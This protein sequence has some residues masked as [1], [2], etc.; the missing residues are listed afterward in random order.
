M[1][2]NI[3]YSHFYAQT[4]VLSWP[5]PMIFFLGIFWSQLVLFTSSLM[6][7][8]GKIFW[9]ILLRCA[10]V[11]STHSGDCFW[12]TIFYSVRRTSFQTWNRKPGGQLTLF[13]SLCMHFY[14]W[15]I[16]V[17]EYIVFVFPFVRSYV[18]SC[19]ISVT[20]KFLVKVSPMVYISVTADQKA[21]I[22][23]P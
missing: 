12:E 2:K 7:C 3:L 13:Q 23:G 21:F 11:Y 4:F 18:C 17:E 10:V 15:V 6:S 1:D 19:I 8:L 22:F 14:I 20:T 5:M 16:Y 9:K